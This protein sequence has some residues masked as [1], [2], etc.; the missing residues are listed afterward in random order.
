MLLCYNYQNGITD[1][2]KDI[3]FVIKPKMFSIG[4]IILLEVMEFVKTTNVEIMDIDVKTNIS[5]Q[6][7]QVQNIEK[8][9]LGNRYEPQIALG[10]KVYRETYY[11]HQ[12]GSATMDEILVKI[13]AEELQ[14]ARWMLTKNQQSM[15]LNLGIDA[16]LDGEN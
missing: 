4:I 6:G 9:I 8:K 15:K 2:E 7:S 16:K 13:K 10:D 14:I 1:E 11:R 3:I 5:A 12:L